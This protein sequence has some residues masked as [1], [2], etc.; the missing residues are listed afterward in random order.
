MWR[1]IS[2]ITMLIFWLS[3][4]GPRTQLAPPG[5]DKAALQGKVMEMNPMWN[6]SRF[7]TVWAELLPGKLVTPVRYEFDASYDVRLLA[8]RQ[9]LDPAMMAQIRQMVD[10]QGKAAMLEQGLQAQADYEAW[11]ARR[12]AG[13]KVGEL[14][15]FTDHFVLIKRNGQWLMEHWQAGAAPLTFTAPDH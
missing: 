13:M 11:L 15:R 4:C 12:T 9:D 6:P 2:S 10:S 3:A 1:T 7:Q 5:L 14:R 8:P